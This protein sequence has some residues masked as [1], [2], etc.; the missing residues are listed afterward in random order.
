MSCKFLFVVRCQ[1]FVVVG[2]WF[3]GA[4]P[5]RANVVDQLRRK[6]VEHWLQHSG[7]CSLEKPPKGSAQEMLCLIQRASCHAIEP[8]LAWICSAAVSCR[9]VGP[10]LSAE[11]AICLPTVSRANES[12]SVTSFQ[13]PM[14]FVGSVLT[15]RC[16]DA[17]T[18]PP[19]PRPKSLAATPHLFFRQVLKE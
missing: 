12:H 11:L 17:R 9:N 4:S 15:A 10:M 14:A 13:M 7:I 1:L 8:P 19:R 6:F 5:D 18:S 16:G 3:D 2:L